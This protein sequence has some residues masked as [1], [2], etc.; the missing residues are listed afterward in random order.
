[1]DDKEQVVRHLEII[2]GVVNRLARNSF[3]TKGWSMTILVAAILFITRDH[4][5][6]EYLILF[7]VIPVISFWA[8]DGYFLWQERLFRGIY[9]EVRLQ[10]KTDF[11]MDTSTQL[12]RPK[13]KCIC[14][15]F[16]STLSIFYAT[17]LFFILVIF[18]ILKGRV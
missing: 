3:L 5:Y 17:E 16:S 11:R 10:E 7:F 14:S 4:N 9:D 13:N 1:M 18:I 8:L 2:Q 12:E 15:V 6:S